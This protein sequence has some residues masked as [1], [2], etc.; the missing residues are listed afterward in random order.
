MDIINIFEYL[1]ISNITMFPI[2]NETLEVQENVENQGEEQSYQFT[3]LAVSF[4]LINIFLVFAL[5]MIK[6]PSVEQV[7]EFVLSKERNTQ[8]SE[9]KSAKPSPKLNSIK[10]SLADLQSSKSQMNR[11]G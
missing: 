11:T 3:L 2:Y 1:D 9:S 10:R 7:K 8:K 6:E 4:L 5:Q